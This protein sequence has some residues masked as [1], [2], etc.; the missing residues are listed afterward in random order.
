MRAR[1]KIDAA[2]NARGSK[3]TIKRHYRAAE[4]VLDNVDVSKTDIPGLK[5]MIAVFE[6]LAEVLDHSGD[7]ERAAKCRQRAAALR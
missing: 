1:T 6:D 3:S 5:D 7:Q 4:K 2:R